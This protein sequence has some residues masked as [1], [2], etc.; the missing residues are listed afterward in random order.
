MRAAD[1]QGL[2]ND[3]NGPTCKRRLCQWQNFFTKCCGQ[4]SDRIV[5]AGRAEINR[6][7]VIN[8]C[9]GIRPATRESALCTL[10]LRKQVIDLIDELAGIC[11]Q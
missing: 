7:A 9:L 10:C 5:T 4:P 6:D 2:V 3:S 1:T 8:Q 11:R